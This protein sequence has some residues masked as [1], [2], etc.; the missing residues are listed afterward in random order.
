MQRR[1]VMVHYCCHLE[2]AVATRTVEIQC[3]A[4]ALAEKAAIDRFGYV[5]SHLVIVVNFTR[6]GSGQ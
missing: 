2:A 1:R 6:P 5:I 4:A 3:V